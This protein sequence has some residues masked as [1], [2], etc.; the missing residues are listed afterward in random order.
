MQYNGRSVDSMPTTPRSM[1]L[2][3]VVQAFLVQGVSFH[4]IQ[5][6]TTQNGVE[7]AN[8]GPVA[9]MVQAPFPRPELSKANQ[10]M[11]MRNI[12]TQFT[13]NTMGTERMHRMR[14]KRL[15]DFATEHSEKSSK[16]DSHLKSAINDTAQPFLK[17]L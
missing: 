7:P 10:A 14:L 9:N 5:N 15:R 4:I 11:S 17:Q 8:L 3:V 6:G 1:E 12:L 13:L 2:P 16:H